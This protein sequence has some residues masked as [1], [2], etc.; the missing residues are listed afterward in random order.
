M[1]RV[2][3]TI[4]MTTG[5]VAFVAGAAWMMTA[6]F[7]GGE[8]ATRSFV[9]GVVGHVFGGGFLMTVAVWVF[10]KGLRGLRSLRP[11]DIDVAAKEV[12]LLAAQSA[13]GRVM[14][15][16]VASALSLA[17]EQVERLLGWLS[18][19]GKCRRE[20]VEGWE[21]YVFEKKGA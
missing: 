9:W 11:F 16:Q 21:V 10:A 7:P 15:P 13:F 14:V 17:P 12:E 18:S 8:G 4:Q 1:A 19:S 3:R 2:G 6:E 5:A 20:R